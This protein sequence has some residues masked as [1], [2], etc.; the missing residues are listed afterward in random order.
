[1]SLRGQF[2]NALVILDTRTIEVCLL[3][4][5]FDRQVNIT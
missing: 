5:N 4:R 3:R 2:F 1:M